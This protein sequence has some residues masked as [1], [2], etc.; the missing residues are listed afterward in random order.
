MLR[1]FADYCAT[2]ESK[3][4]AKTATW[5]QRRLFSV[6]RRGQRAGGWSRWSQNNSA[7]ISWR[8]PGRRAFV[9][10]QAGGL[11]LKPGVDTPPVR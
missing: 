1:S 4:S 7:K 9:G 8:K 5:R 11:I 10:V 3:L 6:H 2:L